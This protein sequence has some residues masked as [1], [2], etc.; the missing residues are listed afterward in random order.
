MSKV[1]A[2]NWPR[3]I[4][5]Y[6]PNMEFA[7]DVVGDLHIAYLGSPSTLDADGIWDG[8]S[9]TDSA[10][11]YTS[12]DYKSTFD[13]SSTSVTTTAGMLSATYGQC[14]TATGSAGSNHVCT[15]IGRDYLG[16]AM[17]ENLTL[18]GTTVIYGNKAFKYVD[19]MSIAIGA[20]SDTVD[21]GWYD[22]LGLP[23][24]TEMI[25]GYTE[26]DVIMPHEAVE[27][28]V[29]VD[30]TR[31]A[32]GTDVLVPSPVAG[33]ITGVNS[34]VT[35]VTA[36]ISTSTVVVGATDVAGL[37]LVIASSA[38]VAT[39][40]SDVATTDDDQ[41]TSTVAK[42]GAMGISPDST[43][44]AG[45]ANYL[46]TVEPLCF[47]AGDDTATQTATTEDTRGTIRVP[48][49]CDGSVSYEVRCKVDTAD[50]H[51]IEQFNG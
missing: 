35:T 16:Q 49:A 20:A 14:L 34:V 25:V 32:A 15:I 8:V 6:V 11:S 9:A 13:G 10:T 38:A 3:S 47:V 7:A 41:V 4:S 26:D 27:V 24:K 5:Q 42:Y 43:P 36:G 40:D 48:T 28:L 18:S 21:I 22:R 29:E 51:G 17:R 37:S 45:A 23:Y 12:A 1:N 39:L 2:D 46:V 30:A 50:L 33:Q 31:F 19:S 44:S